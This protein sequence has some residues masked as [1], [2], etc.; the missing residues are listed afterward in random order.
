MTATESAFDK[1]ASAMEKARAKAKAL[2]AQITAQKQRVEQLKT[3]VTQAEKAQADLTKELERAR[4]EY[5]DGTK[6]VAALEQKVTEA[7][8]RTQKWKQALADATT[9]L[10]KMEQEL[11][12]I[13]NSVQ[14]VGQSMQDAGAAIKGVSDKIG[15]VGKTMTTHITAPIAAVGAAAIASFKEVDEGMDTIVKK[16]GATGDALTEMQDIAKDLAGTLPTSFAAAGEAVGEVNTRFGLTG[17]TLEEL[18]GKFIKF[19]ELNDV[20]VTTAVDSVQSAMAAWGLSAE[21]AGAMLDTLNAVAQGTGT[22]VDSLA[23][24]MVTNVTTL[25]EIGFSASDAAWFLGELDKNGVDASSTMSGLKKALAN[26]SE[27][28]ISM[29]DAL[30]DL[31]QTM[32]DSD[33]DADAY[34]EAME[35]FGTKAGPQLA[36][37]LKDGRLSLDALGTSLD[38]N[39]GNVETTFDNTLDPIDD[40]Q[41]AL[42][43]AK[44]AGSELGTAIQTSAAPLISK[45]TEGIKTATQWF[46]S[47]DS[48]TQQTILTVAGVA[49]AVGPVLTVI[50]AIGSGIGTLISGI[51]GIVSGIGGAIPV[52]T[53]IGTV[54]TGTVI[55]AIGSVLVAIA[56]VLPI[57]AGVAAAI[58]AVILIVKNWGQISEWFSGVWDK[59][60]TGVGDAM[61]KLKTG[62]SNGWETVKTKTTETWN[63]VKTSVSNAWNGMNTAATTIGNMIKTSVTEKWTSI[64]TSA[65]NIWTGI[66]STI[67][68]NMTTALNTVS[69]K[70]SAIKN[71][72]SEKLNAAK[73][74]VSNVI[75][76]IKGLFNFSWSLPKLK[77]PH[78]SI[79]GKFSLMP[80]SIPKFSVSWYKKAYSDPVLF[81][82]P[83]VLSTASGY[84]GFG[85]GSGGEIVI[86]Q[87]MMQNMI[88]DA[89]AAGG[90]HYGDINIVVNGAAGQDVEELADAVAIRFQH[91]INQRGAV[92][93]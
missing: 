47:L 61:D 65:S 24:S 43:N 79:T 1:N 22:S 3:F 87:S 34:A 25:Q 16:T 19:A 66:K 27:Q 86:G 51:G 89:V 49:A 93:A 52:I 85:D 64:K 62:I 35:L 57:I 59:V 39:L 18:S 74:T 13:P 82:S 50:G 77:M 7:D 42:N 71:A 91:M 46:T 60:T 53:G 45:L 38:D 56:P 48:S 14:L 12:D 28:G 54:I 37:A 9:E 31:Q 81:T 69:E 17:D 41:V 15:S 90:A 44:I 20:D 84:K 63:N 36:A 83:T 23:D 11:K 6:E 4:A 5:G 58:A 70:V 67:T 55:P 26:A 68:T 21:D 30:A 73:E 92:W 72:F 40:F 88:R 2:T 10:H 75:S 80:L 78:V 29:E 32:I 33:S 76:K 8:T